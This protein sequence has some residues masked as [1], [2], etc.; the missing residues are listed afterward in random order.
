M[1]KKSPSTLPSGDQPKKSPYR[2]RYEGRFYDQVVAQGMSLAYEKD[3]LAFVTRPEKRRYIPDWTVAPGWFIETKGKL[4]PRDRKKLLYVKEQH[5]TAR[6]LIVFQRSEIP[7]YKGSPT[8]HGQWATKAG[9]EWCDIKDS[10]VWIR[11]IQEANSSEQKEERALTA[12]VPLLPV[13]A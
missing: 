5:P 1:R 3:V 9:Y 8:S 6:I 7:I 2:S 11:F 10:E 4:D 12:R 13:T